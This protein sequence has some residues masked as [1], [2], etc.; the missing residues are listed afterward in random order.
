MRGPLV[1]ILCEMG[2]NYYKEFVV[3]K[4]NQWYMCT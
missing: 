3:N 4:N 2:Q 1:E